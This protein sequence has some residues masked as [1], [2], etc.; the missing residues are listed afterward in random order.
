MKKLMFVA[1]VAAG[2]AAIGD[3]IESSNTVGYNTVTINKEYTILGIPFT[4]TTGA[5]M[6]IQDAVPY[7]AG[8]TKGAAAS[9]A[10]NIQIMDSEGNYETYFM[11]NGYKGKGTITGGDGKWVKSTESAVST[12][13]M[14]AGTPFWYVSKN[15]ATPYTITVAGQVLSTDSSQTPLN[16][17]Y[18]LIANP[19]PCDL[20]LNDGVPFVEG[21]T[22]GAAASAADNIQIMDDE[23]NYATYFMCNGYKGKGTITGGDG[24]WVKSTESAVSTDVL[25]VGKGGWFVRKS[26]SLVNITIANPNAVTQQ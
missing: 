25:P 14:P 12:T 23:G 22:K 17:T 4:G 7:C 9:A 16:V 11:C 18:Q 24:K 3:G 1:A 8:M 6:S 21:M 13:T 2:L 19:Y 10:D 20:P 26:A 5:A 15:Y